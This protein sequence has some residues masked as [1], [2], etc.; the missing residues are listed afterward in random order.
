MSLA[1]ASGGSGASAR[2]ASASSAAAARLGRSPHLGERGRAVVASRQAD[3]AV[4]LER[5]GQD[6]AEA[7]VVLGGQRVLL[8]VDD[9]AR[10]VGEEPAQ[11][12]LA[13]KQ[14]ERLEVAGGVAG[15]QQHLEDERP[16]AGAGV[17]L[18]A[19]H[20]DRGAA[21]LD[22]VRLQPD[23]D[24]AG[25]APQQAPVLAALAAAALQEQRG[26]PLRAVELHGEAGGGD[27]AL[28]H[29]GAHVGRQAADG[30]GAGHQ[31]RLF[32]QGCQ[33]QSPPAP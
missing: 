27:V 6:L 21:V 4:V 19:E 22:D 23:R 30:G 24:R 12:R 28:L 15:Q 1:A 33:T 5:V 2:A 17:R 11:A 25:R 14:L 31:V 9:L 10:A 13:A 20:H 18:G 3:Q 8:R 29:G 32:G 7:C 26:L 16:L